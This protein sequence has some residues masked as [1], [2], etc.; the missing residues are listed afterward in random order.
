MNRALT[1]GFLIS[2][3]CGQPARATNPS[4]ID[5]K[6]RLTGDV[7][8]YHMGESI[9]FEISYASESERKYLTSLSNPTPEFGSV[10]P[11]LAP[12]EGALDTRTLRPCWGG[13]AGSFLSSGPQYLSSQP[14]KEQGELTSWYRFQKPGHYSLTVTSRGVSRVRSTD[15][16]G[17]QAVLNL[18][19]NTVEFDI[20]P[21][22]PA[23]ESQQLRTI[24]LDLGNA[25]NPGDRA[26]AQHRLTLLDTPDSARKMVELFLSTPYPERYAYIFSLTQSSQI[27][28]II[29]LLE[30]ALSDSEINP[31]GV[32][33]LL[34]Q[35]QVRKQ[36]GLNTPTSD[37][38]ARKQQAQAECQEQRKLYD[39]YLARGNAS[40]LARAARSS[41]SQQSTVIFE[42]WSSAEDQ[43]VQSGQAPANLTQ[44]RLAVLNVAETLDPDQQTQFVISEWKILPHEQLLPLIRNLAS[45]HRLDA[46][47][48]WCEGW[49]DECSGAIL[50]DALR[51]D[52]QVMATHVLLMSEAEHP[53]MNAPLREQLTSPGILQDSTRSVRTAALILRAATRELLPDVN[54][55]LTRSAANHG[56]NC[57]VEA[58]LIGYLF[59]VAVEDAQNRLS[60]LLQDEKCGDQL[61]RLL[62]MAR[63][64]DALVP[65]AVKALDSPNLSAAATAALFLG[66][67]GSAET[68]DA[69]WRRLEAL[70]VL[71]HYRAGELRI[72]VPTPD[73]GIQWQSARLE[74]SLVSALSHA[75]NWE[76][77]PSER[78]RLR[79][80]CLTEQ[81]QNIADGKMRLGL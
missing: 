17:G 35:L 76:L 61:F 16:G 66:E 14:I 26:R 19:S 73:R 52:T 55:T 34:A 36:V 15:E 70:W 63:Y 13:I 81:C 51:S 75:N 58:Y 23:W 57:Q 68:E 25:Q 62:N 7:S 8:S 59:R 9:G 38:P 60:E 72:T 39:A 53:E 54:E 28:L 12:S 42:A 74:Q 32:A 65:V 3:A 31:A 64:S 44:L 4:D 79:D 50:S 10:S 21:S 47:K 27:D 1:F 22:D 45:T 41:G 48:L 29:P 77:T 67:H 80:S 49:S 11:Q 40:L 56:F 71:W 30:A 6:L 43:N 20:L 37:D 5:F 69:L 2:L 33:E 18:E 46:Y 24:L 78:D